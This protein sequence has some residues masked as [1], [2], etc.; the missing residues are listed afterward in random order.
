M[1]IKKED[2]VQTV[3]D[4]MRGGDGSVDKR[5]YLFTAM[6]ENAKML[7]EIRL[8]PGCSIGAH[9]HVG[10]YEIFFCKEG[11]ITLN[12]GGEEK[13]MHAGDCGIC[14]DG[15]THGMANRTDKPAAIYAAIIRTK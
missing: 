10:E 8:E 9:Q 7:A 12:D 1:L 15:A 6:P 4:R 11:E 3:I 5:D 2:R 14:P 13:L